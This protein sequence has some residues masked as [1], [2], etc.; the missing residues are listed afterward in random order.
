MANLG[1]FDNVW[2]HQPLHHRFEIHTRLFHF[3]QNDTVSTPI[4]LCP[5]RGAG[6]IGTYLTD[7]AWGD[8]KV[9]TLI[10][11]PAQYYKSICEVGECRLGG[12]A[13]SV[14]QFNLK[15]NASGTWTFHSTGMKKNCF[16]STGLIMFET[17]LFIW[18]QINLNSFLLLEQNMSTEICP[19]EWNWSESFEYCHYLASCMTYLLCPYSMIDLLRGCDRPSYWLFGGL[20]KQQRDKFLGQKRSI[21]Q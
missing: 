5:H 15:M 11:R 17:Q 14:S 9:K 4:D 18:M 2:F 3:T 7:T 12:I 8:S 13:K 20:C 1:S 6:P 19:N 16:N 21:D 10:N